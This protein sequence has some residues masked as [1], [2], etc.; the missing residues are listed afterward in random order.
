MGR[1]VG[2]W[3]DKCNGREW[4]DVLGWLV[5]WLIESMVHCRVLATYQPGYNTLWSRNKGSCS[6]KGS[7][8]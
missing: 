2:G 5:D 3:V 7:V 8:W 4:T 1:W 6:A